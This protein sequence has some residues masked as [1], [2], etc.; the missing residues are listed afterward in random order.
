MTR[1]RLLDDP[2]PRSGAWNMAVD[3]ALWARAEEGSES[4][5]TVRLYAWR[6]ACLSLGYHQT[7]HEACDAAFCEREGIGVVRRPTGGKAVLH[8]DEVTY[9]VVAPY[10]APPFASGGLLEAY[11]AIARALAEG[12]GRLGLPVSLEERAAARP[13]TG[14]DPCFL[15]PSP[16]EL[17]SGGRKV[18]GSAQKRGRRAFLQHGAVPLSIDYERL[19]LA[20][21][22][23]AL[24]AVRYREAFA[25]VADLRL[26]VTAQ[27]LRRELRAGFA[28]V[29]H[30]EVENGGLSAEESSLA[31]T[32]SVSR[33]STREWT[34]G[35]HGPDLGIAAPARRR[36]LP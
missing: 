27:D 6:P 30:G 11:E 26:G 9:S 19:A 3:E 32:L 25:G 29:F 10:G 22:R 2:V 28:R 35:A 1:W 24:D 21:G 23:P 4:R 31:Q 18:A 15:V 16:K 12:L 14:S 13:P 7:L 34:E 5:V 8:D 33:Y 17:L 20:S 36:A